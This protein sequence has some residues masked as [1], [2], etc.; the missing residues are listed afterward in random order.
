MRIICDHREHY[1]CQSIQSAGDV[2]IEAKA[3]NASAREICEDRSVS[4]D[5]LGHITQKEVQAS[6]SKAQIPLSDRS[7]RLAI[8][9]SSVKPSCA[10]GESC[11]PELREKR[12]AWSILMQ[13]AAQK[14]PG[15]H[16]FDKFISDDEE[17]ELIDFIETCEPPWNQSTFNGPHRW[18]LFSRI[19]ACHLTV[20]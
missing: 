19:S 11:S 20:P 5:S 1:G 12:P 17:Q 4:P 15:H 6:D 16:L 3:C 7:E 8:P 2:A 10:N 13:S 18:I 14:L 9:S